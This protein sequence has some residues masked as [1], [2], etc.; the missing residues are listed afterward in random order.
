MGKKAPKQP[1]FAILNPLWAQSGMAGEEL[2]LMVT[3]TTYV[4]QHGVVDASHGAIG[5]ACGRTRET[6]QRRMPI[7]LRE[8]PQFVVKIGDFKYLLIG[9]SRLLASVFSGGQNAPS[10]DETSQ[11]ESGDESS[12]VAESCD[13]SSQT[14]CEVLSQNHLK[15][16][17]Q[18]TL[19]L[20]RERAGEETEPETEDIA[21]L[22]AEFP[23]VDVAEELEKRLLLRAT[24]TPVRAWI[25]R[26]R[27]YQ[28][29]K[30]RLKNDQQPV[31][32][33]SGAEQQQRRQP[34]CG[35]LSLP[36]IPGKAATPAQ[37]V[38]SWATSLRGDSGKLIPPDIRDHLW[39]HLPA[40]LAE[41]GTDLNDGPPT[42]VK[43]VGK[44]FTAFL[45]RHNLSAPDDEAMKLDFA[46]L[47]G[48]PVPAFEASAKWIWEFYRYRRVPTIGDF[49][50]ALEAVQADRQTD[51]A[52][53]MELRLRLETL[54][55]Q[56]EW[57]ARFDRWRE[58][59]R[60]RDPNSLEN[61]KNVAKGD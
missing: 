28:N 57:Q 21:A 30:K 49:R 7:L 34:T 36:M 6:V 8:W 14:T 10:C 55:L 56:E 15:D 59:S 40:A 45:D 32:R 25:V 42:G 44:F 46:C 52:H 31:C 51:R 50:A 47:A 41:A 26:A 23:D 53:L 20:P 35:I 2:L 13:E 54:R 29:K 27:I 16:S 22:Q 19:S 5:R 60:K 11:D 38:L 58:S 3:L 33:S 37:S 48:W 24:F 43:A 9:H 18:K 39:R 61:L 17:L 1:R 4:D 12:H